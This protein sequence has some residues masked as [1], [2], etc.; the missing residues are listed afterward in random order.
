MK[1]KEFEIAKL[2][3]NTSAFVTAAPLLQTTMV[4]ADVAVESITDKSAKEGLAHMTLAQLESLQRV[5][6]TSGN[7]DVKVLAFTKEF[8]DT[9]FQTVIDTEEAGQNLRSLLKAMGSTTLYEQ[10]MGENGKIRWEQYEKDIADLVK[11]KT[12]EAGALRFDLI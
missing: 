2:Q 5:Q 3:L 11:D 10:Y 1:K 7:A 9:V 4:T 8:Y 12:I 6:K